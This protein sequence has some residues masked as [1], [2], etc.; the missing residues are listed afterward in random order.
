MMSSIRIQPSK[1]QKSSVSSSAPPRVLW[2]AVAEGRGHL[3]RAH[4]VGVALERRGGRVE[5]LTT[6]EEGRAFLAELGRPSE[7]LSRHY[8]LRFDDRHN[9]ARARS[10]AA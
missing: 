5:I 6:S 2:L 1:P 9:L 7:V 4:A 3:V 10:Q 8:A